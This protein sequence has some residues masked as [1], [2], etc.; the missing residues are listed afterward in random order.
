MNVREN[1][2]SQRP[3]VGQYTMKPTVYLETTIIGYLA[4]RPS[5]DLLVA[6]S[7]QVTHQWWDNARGDFELRASRF[8]VNECSAGDPVAAQERLVHLAGIPLLELSDEVNKLGALLLAGAGLPKRAQI[9]ALHVSTAAVHGIE[10]LLTWN[11]K[12]IASPVFRPRME[13]TCR[14]AGYEPPVIC[15]PQELLGTEHAVF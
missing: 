9:D 11:C 6:A 12:H 7:Q 8:V 14:E 5:R 4:M 2:P 3:G 15:N 1:I 13:R 10:Y